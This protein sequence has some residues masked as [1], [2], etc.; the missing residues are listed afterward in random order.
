MNFRILALVFLEKELLL[1]TG[2]VKLL[3]KSV[4]ELYHFI[5]I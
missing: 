3:N 5:K 1:P 2:I 4:A